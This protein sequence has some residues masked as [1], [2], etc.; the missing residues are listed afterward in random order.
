MSN[1]RLLRL[2]SDIVQVDHHTEDRI[3]QRLTTLVNQSARHSPQGEGGNCDA[4][5][6]TDA[7]GD[8]RGS[9]DRLASGDNG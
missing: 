9:G 7:S 2:L 3:N 6:E 8:S 4:P 5:D 1:E